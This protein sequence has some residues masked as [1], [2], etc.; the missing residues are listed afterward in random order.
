MFRTVWLGGKIKMKQ[1]EGLIIRV[2]MMVLKK[3]ESRLVW[4]VATFYSLTWG[5]VTSVRDSLD[6]VL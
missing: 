5:T 1:R 4:A 2:Q 6:C 3:R